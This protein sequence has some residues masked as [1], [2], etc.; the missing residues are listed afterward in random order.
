MTKHF[1][2]GLFALLLSATAFSQE[3]FYTAPFN[4]R[5]SPKM[6]EEQL[7]SKTFLQ[8]MSKQDWARFSKDPR[9]DANRVTELKTNWKRESEQAMKQMRTSQSSGESNCYWIDPTNEY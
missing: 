2:Y 7:Y 8:K 5:Y 6:T 4:A 3:H 1:I 9:F